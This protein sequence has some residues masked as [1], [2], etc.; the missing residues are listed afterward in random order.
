MPRA[1]TH[2]SS[3][4]PLCGA[5]LQGTQHPHLSS[6]GTY[7]HIYVLTHRHYHLH[8]IQKPTKQPNN[9][10]IFKAVWW[11]PGMV[12]HAVIQHWEC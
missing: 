3:E 2:C 5:Q 9:S 6:V 1:L 8:M 4:R 10:S 11:R 7:A 12:A